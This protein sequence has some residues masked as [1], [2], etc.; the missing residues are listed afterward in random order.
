MKTNINFCHQIL[1]FSEHIVI[2]NVLYINIH[3]CE[4]FFFLFVF[5]FVVV[6]VVVFVYGGWGEGE[7]GGRAVELL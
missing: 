7:R 5:C 2:I 3:S 4:F 6:V 1:C